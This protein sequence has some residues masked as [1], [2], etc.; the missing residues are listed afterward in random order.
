M[1]VWSP[2]GKQIAFASQ[3]KGKW[4]IYVKAADGTGNE[5]LLF[6]SDLAKAPMSWS[7]DGKFILYWLQDPKTSGDEW[8]V[9]LAGDRKPFPLLHNAFNERW[10]QISPDGKWIAYTSNETRR[11]EIYVTSFPNAQGKWQLSTSGG[12]FPRWRGDGKELYFFTTLSS[13]K[14]MATDIRATG[15]SLQP[16]VPRVLFDSGYVDIPLVVNYHPYATSPDGQ[17]FL[18]PRPESASAAAS[19]QAPAPI[20]V[21]LNWTAALRRE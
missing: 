4:G 7:P 10:A 6:E 16:A 21:V 3:R 5:E 17:R 8:V 19:D 13:G 12:T 2:D 9:P 14:L 11:N 15:S 18:I 1:P 20:T